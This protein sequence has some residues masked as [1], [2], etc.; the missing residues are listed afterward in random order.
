MELHLQQEIITDES[1]DV[2]RDSL[3]GGIGKKRG[4]EKKDNW[5]K[6]GILL[7]SIDRFKTLWEINFNLFLLSQLLVQIRVQILQR[8][9]A[10]QT[11]ITDLNCSANSTI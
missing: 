5:E 3:F 9:A 8:T 2:V 4:G 6:V 7:I 1:Y 10:S 11:E